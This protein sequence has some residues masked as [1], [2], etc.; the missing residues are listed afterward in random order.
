MENITWKNI[1]ESAEKQNTKINE[2]RTKKSFRFFFGWHYRNKYKND[3][4]EFQKFFKNIEKFG[5]M[6]YHYYDIEHG[7]C[8][9][10]QSDK[11]I[12][13]IKSF[14]RR[15]ISLKTDNVLALVEEFKKRLAFENYCAKVL[16]EYSINYLSQLVRS[17]IHIKKSHKNII[18]DKERKTEI[19]KNVIKYTNNEL[20]K[21]K[22]RKD[23]YPREDPNDENI[24]YNNW[25]KYFEDLK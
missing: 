6:Y 5:K 24:N 1:Y 4:S 18:L 19:V 7:N 20:L 10:T 9:S 2:K 25:E 17:Q 8:Q 11:T 22:N 14:M 13:A 12:I 21:I 23:K 15:D 16:R 3:D